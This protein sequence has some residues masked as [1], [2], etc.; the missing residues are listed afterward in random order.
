MLF[1]GQFSSTFTPSNIYNVE[2]HENQ[3]PKTG[4]DYVQNK[5][6]AKYSPWIHNFGY[7]V[8]RIQFSG[9]VLG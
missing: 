3:I 5:L 4:I 7:I 6:T 8:Y 9:N 2:V 1:T